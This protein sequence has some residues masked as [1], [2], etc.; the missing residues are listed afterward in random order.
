MQYTYNEEMLQNLIKEKCEEDLHLEYK[1]ASKLDNKDAKEEISK[2]IS[3]FANADGGILV[4]GIQEFN[5][6][7]KKH[8][9]EKITP[10]DRSIYTKEWLEQVINSNIHPRI[11][12]TEI[13]IISITPHD[14]K[15]VYWIEIPKSD[16]V[17][18]AKD[19][20][21]YRRYNF[22][23][24]SMLDHEIRDVMNRSSHPILNLIL[25]DELTTFN[26]NILKFPLLIAN[27]SRIL[28]EKV[29][30][31]ITFDNYSEYIIHTADYTDSSDVNP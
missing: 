4:L 5:E 18:Q 10:I 29:Q 27:S 17:H 28:A 15:V 13:H 3:A 7:N 22:Q 9:P 12:G 23:V 21:Y 26:G 16:T 1:S 20:K 11:Q 24:L 2:N 30:L 25:S 8:L 19:Q 31:V 14:N 6:E